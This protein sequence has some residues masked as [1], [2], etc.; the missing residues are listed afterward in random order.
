VCRAP[1]LAVVDCLRGIAA[2]IVFGVALRIFFRT[3]FN[4]NFGLRSIRAA[5]IAID[6]F[7]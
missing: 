1:W 5:A 3:P 2:L 6:L 4:A 7:L